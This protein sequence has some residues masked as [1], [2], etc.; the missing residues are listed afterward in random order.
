MLRSTDLAHVL[1]RQRLHAGDW[2]IDATMGNGYDTVF[3]AA[4]VGTDGHV[5]ACDPQPAA[6]E[7]TKARFEREAAAMDQVTLMECGHQHLAATLPAASFQVIMFNLGYLPGG[8]KAYTT[9][10]ETTLAGIQAAL[11][12]LKSTGLI[13]IITYPG[14]EMGAVEAVAVDSFLQALPHPF[15]LHH[16]RC[17]NAKN[18][19]PELY[20]VSC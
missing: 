5:Y 12:L 2:A 15:K 3:L 14:H 7:A 19:P 17:R 18:P 4:C 20:L 8:D 10:P 6:H 9:Q 13:T 11:K 1:I 16:Y